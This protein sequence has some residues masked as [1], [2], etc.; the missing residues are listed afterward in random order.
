MPPESSEGLSGFK[1]MAKMQPPAVAPGTQTG[2]EE[3]LASSY[4]DLRRKIALEH[5]R[6]T[7]AGYY[8]TMTTRRSASSP[9]TDS[10]ATSQPASAAAARLGKPVG[11]A[12]PA[13]LQHHMLPPLTAPAIFRRQSYAAQAA[14]QVFDLPLDIPKANQPAAD[15]ARPKEHSLVSLKNLGVFSATVILVF[16]F[17]YRLSEGI[18]SSVPN[19]TVQFKE[20][21]FFSLRS[22]LT[23]S[24]FDLAPVNTMGRLLY[25]VEGVVGMMTMIVVSIVVSTRLAKL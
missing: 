20:D 13:P 6:S 12:E 19:E 23:A 22:F 2:H 15:T 25:S 8:P 24:S 21:F 3:T 4:W 11:I 18:A 9:A 7:N 16:A 10:V 1:G 17:L 14:A 5:L